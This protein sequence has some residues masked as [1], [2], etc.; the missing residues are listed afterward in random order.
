MDS[1]QCHSDRD[2]AAGAQSPEGPVTTSGLLSCSLA[3]SLH[4]PRLL[5]S[6]LLTPPPLSPLSP[7]SVSELLSLIPQPPAPCHCPAFASF[8]TQ[9]QSF[10]GFEPPVI[11]TL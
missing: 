7:L 11:E 4:S 9:T 1:V 6:V 3:F 2:P 10:A 8:S 5:A